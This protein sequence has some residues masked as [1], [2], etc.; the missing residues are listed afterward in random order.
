MEYEI[1]EAIY[2]HR[3]SFKFEQDP[4][5]AITFPSRSRITC[6]IISKIRYQSP[7]MLI[8]ETRKLYYR[9][10]AIR[11]RVMMKLF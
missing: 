9:I 3:I 7:Y 6:R 1:R 2:D 5:K 11:L 10:P 4:Q 8:E